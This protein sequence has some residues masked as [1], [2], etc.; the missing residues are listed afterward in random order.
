M[1]G[2]SAARSNL[3]RWRIAGSSGRRLNSSSEC[4]GSRR[5]DPESHEPTP[6]ILTNIETGRLP[7]DKEEAFVNHEFGRTYPGRCVSTLCSPEGYQRGRGPELRE[8]H[9]ASPLGWGISA[10]PTIDTAISHSAG[11]ESAPSIHRP[12]WSL[13]GEPAGCYRYGRPTLNGP[14]MADPRRSPERTRQ[15]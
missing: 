15:D 9:A 12:C 3:F 10:S 1:P 8:L 11:C 7:L 13:P 6:P 2:P 4:P 14:A 5:W